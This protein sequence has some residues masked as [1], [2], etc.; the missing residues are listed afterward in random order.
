[1]FVQTF[2]ILGI[3]REFMRN[4]RQK[5]LYVLHL[6]DRWKQ[7]KQNGKKEGKLDKSQDLALFFNAIGQASVG[8]YKI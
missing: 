6:S 1:M 2:E 8:V 4:L 3:I 7:E 5:N